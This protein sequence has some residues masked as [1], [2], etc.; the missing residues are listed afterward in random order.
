M[1]RIGNQFGFDLGNFLPRPFGIVRWR[2]VQMQ[3]DASKCLSA[4]AIADIPFDIRKNRSA[5]ELC[6]IPR[7]HRQ[8]KKTVDA[9]RRRT[10]EHKTFFARNS[11]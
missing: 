2:I 10:F 11:L 3:I 6:V 9:R 7:P 8:C 4:P 5:K 1:G